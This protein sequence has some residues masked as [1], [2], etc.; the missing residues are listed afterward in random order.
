M[1]Y[2]ALSL[3]NIRGL[4]KILYD[5][6]KII[7]KYLFEIRLTSTNIRKY[8]AQLYNNLSFK[9]INVLIKIREYFWI[10]FRFIFVIYV[11]QVY[12]R[13]LLDEK[14]VKRSGRWPYQNSYPNIRIF[15]KIFDDTSSKCCNSGEIIFHHLLPVH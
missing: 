11:N 7:V 13:W 2:D 9:R 14:M 12:W 3:Q 6:I 8:I 4:R 15:I 5:F 10:E 1:I